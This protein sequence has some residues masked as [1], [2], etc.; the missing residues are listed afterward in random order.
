[1][2]LSRQ[3][4]RNRRNMEMVNN[5]K[6]ETASFSEKKRLVNLEMTLQ[7][8]C[9][10]KTTKIKSEYREWKNLVYVVKSL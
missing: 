9:G 8:D 5:T 2:H 4:E 1:V 7:G 6:G 3:N 10:N